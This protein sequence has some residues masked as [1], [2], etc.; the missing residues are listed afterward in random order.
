MMKLIF[1]RHFKTKGNQERRYVGVT[2]ESIEQ[3]WLCHQKNKESFEYPKVECVIVSPKKRCLETA[4]YLY[5]NCVP[6]VIKAFE[7][8]D[9]GDFEYKNHEELEQD[10]RYQKWVD[11]NGQLPF[12]NGESREIFQDRCVEAFCH[13]ISQLIEDHIQSVA[14]VV[15]GG[16]I[17]SIMEAFGY[18]HKEYFDWQVEN[19]HG[20]MGWLNENQWKQG[21]KMVEEECT[22]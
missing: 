5:P 18:P 11:S 10:I 15:H 4:Q 7:E 19:G 1:I 2:D 3:P 14:F 12:P 20:F 17:M 6:M 13:I 8:C 22:L 16:T 9:F 21:N